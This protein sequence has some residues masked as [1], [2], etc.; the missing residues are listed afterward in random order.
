MTDFGDNLYSS[1]VKCGLEEISQIEYSSG[2]YEFDI[3]AV[4]RQVSTGVLFT[5]RDS[6]CSCPMPFE[7]V[8]SMEELD[9]VGPDF[10]AMIQGE[11]RGNENVSPADYDSF[12]R[13]VDKAMGVIQQE[14]LING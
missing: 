1:P 8:K 6:G 9:R 4:W 5:Y 2:H 7:Y 14:G 3:R 12:M 10:R 13:E 11:C